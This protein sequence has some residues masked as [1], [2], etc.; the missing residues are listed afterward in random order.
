MSMDAKKYFTELKILYE[1][2]KSSGDAATGL[3]ILMLLL[4][5]DQPSLSIEE[6]AEKYKH[7]IT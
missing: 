4:D 1:I 7:P 2:S 5:E 3:K 6:L